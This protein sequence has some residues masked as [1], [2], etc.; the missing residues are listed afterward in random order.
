M[1]HLWGRRAIADYMG[2]RD[3]RTPL[4]AMKREGLLMFRRRRGSHGRVVWYSNSDLIKAW[5]ISRA[6]MDR[7]R[8][9]GRERQE[10]NGDEA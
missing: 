8:L 1:K 4:Q 7:E 2:W 10:G 3:P 6:Q 9:L 5:M